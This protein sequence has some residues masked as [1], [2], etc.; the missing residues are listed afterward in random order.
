MSGCPAPQT[1]IEAI[2]HC[3]R[4]RGLAALKEPDNLERLK[5]CNAAARMEINRRIGS[6]IAAREIAA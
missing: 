4:E 2:M 1:T 3:V 5:G 6:L